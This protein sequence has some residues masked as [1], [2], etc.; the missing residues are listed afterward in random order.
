MRKEKLAE[1]RNR[2]AQI[3]VVTFGVR[4]VMRFLKEVPRDR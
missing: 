2:K 1:C 3:G 4:K